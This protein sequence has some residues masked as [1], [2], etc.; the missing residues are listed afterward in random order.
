MYCR[1][2]G[3]DFDGPACPRCGSNAASQHLYDVSKNTILAGEYE[4]QIITRP[5]GLAFCSEDIFSIDHIYCY[6]KLYHPTIADAIP[7]YI[8]LGNDKG[9]IVEVN[10]KVFE[11]ISESCP[12]NSSVGI[13]TKTR[14][15]YE[16]IKYFRNLT[17]EEY[18]AKKERYRKFEPYKKQQELAAQELLDKMKE[19]PV[20]RSARSQRTA[21]N[22]NF[23]Q[24]TNNPDLSGR[25]RRVHKKKKPNYIP[26]IALGVILILI[27]SIFAFC[28]SK[29]DDE[30]NTVITNATVEDVAIALGLEG[31]EEKIFDAIGAIAGRGFIIPPAEETE[32]ATGEQVEIYQ[33]DTA[34]EAWKTIE[35]TGVLFVPELEELMPDGF[36]WAAYRNGIALLFI[37]EPNQEIIDNFKALNFG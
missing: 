12:E 9:F 10:D 29:K 1:N 37:G 36:V 8:S 35:D 24:D 21:R 16:A 23:Q 33:F 25:T 26:Y 11:E 2:C 3:I 6:R 22:A 13:P 15:M 4:G 5:I 20:D 18:N 27:I 31:G 28:Q 14:Q 30:P 7:L 32:E 34:S 17:P 19:E